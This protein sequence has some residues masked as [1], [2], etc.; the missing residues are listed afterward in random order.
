MTR[1]FLGCFVPFVL[2]LAVFVPVAAGAEPSGE[3][4]FYPGDH[5]F[6]VPAGVHDLT[7]MA[8]GASGAQVRKTGE[9][10]HGAVVSGSFAVTPGEVLQI[11]VADGEQN[12]YGAGGAHG[13]VAGSPHDGAAGGGASAVVAASPLVIAGGGGGAGGSNNATGGQG[14]DGGSPLG[15]DGNDGNYIESGTDA[16]FVAESIHPGCGGCESGGTGGNGDSDHNAITAG[17]GGGGGG[18][19]A[20]GGAGGEHGDTYRFNEGF[21]WK[22]VEESGAGGG[23]GSSYI[24]SDAFNPSFN[25]DSGC[26]SNGT[27]SPACEGLVTLSWGAPP[28]RLATLSGAGQGIPLTG[29]FEAIELRATDANGL[30]VTGAPVTFSVPSTG[31]SGVLPGGAPTVVVETDATGVARLFGLRSQAPVGAWNLT[32]SIPGSVTTQIPLLNQ[33]IPTEVQPISTPNPSTATETL[34]ISAEVVGTV[35]QLTLPPTGAV[36]FAI[37]GAPLGAAVPLN[38]N[39]GIA[40]VPSGSAPFLL[41]GGH[42]ITAAYLGDP[43]HAAET[44]RQFQQVYA[45]ETAVSVEG[46]PNPVSDGSALDL[47]A[48]ISTRTAGPLPTG[49]VSFESDG[50]ALGSAPVEDG[51][52]ATLKLA[53]LPLGAHEI[54]ALYSGDDRFEPGRGEAIEVVDDA[55]VAAILTSSANPSTFGA[56]AVVKA[57]IRRAEAGPVPFGI[58]DFRVDGALVCK[59]VPTAAAVASCELPSE[60]A[61][62]RHAIRAAFVPGVGSGDADATGAMVQL[63]VQSP[64]VDEVGATPAAAIFDQPFALGSTVLRSDSAAATGS[65]QFQLDRFAA[66]SPIPLAA[67]RATLANACAGAAP[68]GDCPLEVGVHTVASEFSP[69]DGNLR[70]SQAT[71]FIQVRPES[72]EPGVRLAAAASSGAPVSFVATV[73]APSG[74]AE[75]AVQFLLD[76]TVLGAPVELVGGSATSAPTRP[77]TT[78]SHVVVAH[79]LG[80]ERFDPSEARLGFAAADSSASPKLRLLSRAARVEGDG[81]LRVKAVCDGARGTTCEGSLSIRLPAGAD[82]RDEPK[83][84]A[85]A[86]LKL[87]AGSTAAPRLVLRRPGRQMLSTRGTLEARARFSGDSADSRLRLR[88]SRAPRLA[89]VGVHRRYRTFLVRLRCQPPAHSSMRGCDGEVELRADGRRIGV[90]GVGESQA[91]PVTARLRL[92]QSY[93][94][95]PDVEVFVRVHSEIAV[96]EERISTGSFMVRPPVLGSRAPVRPDSP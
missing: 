96:G 53:S 29:S 14:G 59:A 48:T 89:P 24:R 9:S 35:G 79:Y 50:E 47:R 70:R 25:V 58:V 78:G 42:T 82:G 80:A 71:S 57:E 17:G 95:G 32:A 5:T 88:S 37:D 54:T 55:A 92:P 7:V 43:A 38:P 30:P 51:A 26:V 84:L 49:T 41:A 13:K 87:A 16:E 20:Q 39:T 4:N 63:V 94:D 56:G 52:E 12:G 36:Q 19:G 2:V 73:A 65:V 91:G 68:G 34:E 1:R 85:R 40:Q 10:G 44:G 3:Q 15:M 46:M 66:G 76:G 75:G 93:R 67:G 64:T 31:P 77:L 33:A 18:G 81:S 83:L 21:S 69:A 22:E 28:A 27:P 23:G 74:A 90:V 61:A 86:D 8:R 6:V 72:T 11:F 45:E 60:L 62:G